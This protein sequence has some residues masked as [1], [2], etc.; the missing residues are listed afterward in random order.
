MGP[1]HQHAFMTGGFGN[2]YEEIRF[3][4]RRSILCG[5]LA[6]IFFLPGEALTD[7]I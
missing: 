6:T 5:E 3:R 4:E 1:K 2:N 7:A